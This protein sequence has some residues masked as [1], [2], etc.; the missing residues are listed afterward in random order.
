MSLNRANAKGYA[1]A[2]F[3]ASLLMFS[4]AAFFGLEL[5]ESHASGGWPHVPSWVI[6]NFAER[7]CGSK[8]PSWE[9]KIVYRYTVDG[10]ARE[11]GRVGNY[12]LYCDSER[13]VALRWLKNHYSDTGGTTTPPIQMRHFSAP[14]R[15]QKCMSS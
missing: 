4:G 1:I 2:F 9:A 11:A 15:C 10:V 8:T 5:R 13:E 12:P 6:A 3:A 14:A 7:T